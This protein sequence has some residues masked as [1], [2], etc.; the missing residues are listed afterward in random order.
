MNKVSILA[1]Q[2]TLHCLLGCAI[3]EVIGMVLGAHFGWPDL[4]T[5]TVSITLAF[6]SGFLL[7]SLP[8]VRS[9]MTFTRALRLVL[10][11]D[12]LS[13]AVMETVDNLIM[14]AIPGAMDAGLTSLL[15]WGALAFSLAC[16]FVVAY[17]VNRYLLTKGKGHALVHEY[18]HAHAA[19]E[20]DTHADHSQHHHH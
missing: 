10:A 6:I 16:A 12:T 9:G 15:F 7:S 8:L 11:A 19:H 18:H 5:V 4:L 17:P 20:D 1:A 13:I 2:A 14:L 3:G